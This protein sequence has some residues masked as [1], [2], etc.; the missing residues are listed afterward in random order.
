MEVYTEPCGGVLP[1]RHGAP[2]RR[3]AAVSVKTRNG[4]VP[5]KVKEGDR[6]DWEARR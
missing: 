4:T 6:R 3:E 2:S 5:S 1:T